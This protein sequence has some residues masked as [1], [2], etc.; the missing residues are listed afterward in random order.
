VTKLQAACGVLIAGCLALAGG[1]KGSGADAAWSGPGT[2]VPLK[3]EAWRIG[4][5]TGRKISTP[6]Y[7][8][9]TTIE[10][11][12]AVDETAQVM[13]GAY[14]QYLKL[15][16]GLKV[17]DRPMN[18]FIFGNRS[19]WERFTRQYTGAAAATYLKI[20]RGGYAVR[21]WYVAYYLGNYSTYS[22]ASHEGWHQFCG[23]NFKTRLPPFL[24]EG[25][26]CMF[27]GVSMAG[28]QGLPQ[29]NFGVNLNRAV[30]LREA[31][32]G[33]RLW[34]LEKLVTLHAG[35]L[36]DS[37]GQQIDAFY[38]QN[39]AFARFMW[40]AED[41]RYRPALRQMLTD[42]ATGVAFDPATNTKR[43]SQGWRPAAVRPTLE[44]YFARPFAEIE[45][46]YLAF[47]NRIAFEQFEAQWQS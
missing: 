42:A 26:A 44:H 23:R 20:T 37:R 15:V 38:A 16:P 22:V 8:I 43:P 25:I 45:Q 14:Q 5:K 39:W 40:E 24:E 2:P 1:C 21:D 46:A 30:K 34:P 41:G 35:L 17:S 33:R 31:V 28:P 32:N 9:H 6:H 12:R 19:D 18:C 7:T 29:W 27:E 3:V 13:E 4:E 10:D 47:V 36:V 11:N